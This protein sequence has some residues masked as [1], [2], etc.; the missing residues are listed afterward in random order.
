MT[1]LIFALFTAGASAEEIRYQIDTHAD[2]Q[3]ATA[4]VDIE[5]PDREIRL[6]KY[7]PNVTDFL[8]GYEYVY[9]SP[10]GIERMNVD[11]TTTPITTNISDPNN[12]TA[13]AGSGNRPDFLVAEG[14]F[15]TH[16]SFTGNGYSPNPVLSSAGYTGIVS[17]GTKELD[18]AVLTDHL[19]YMAM[20][21]Q[22][23]MAALPYLTTGD[24]TNPIAASVFKDHYGTVV[25]DGTSVKYF[26][27]GNTVTA[28]ITGLQNAMSI[29]ASEGGNIAV[30]TGNQVQHYNLIGNEFHYNS[31]LSVTTGL[32]E[33][34]CIATRPGSYDKLI[35]DGDQIK[36]YMWTGT[37][38][39]YNPALSKTV[40]GLQAM[41]KYMRTAYAES[42]IYPINKP[43]YV[44]LFIDPGL[45]PQEDGTSIEWY[46]TTQP[47]G[48]PTW[49]PITIGQW[50]PSSNATQIRW[51]AVL[52]TNNPK[53]TPRINPDI[54]IK[55]NTKPLPPTPD[56]PPMAGDD[57][58]YYTTSPEIRW[59]FND[60]PDDFQGGYQI[61]IKGGSLNVSSGPISAATNA[62]TFDDPSTGKI[63]DSGVSVFEVTIKTWDEVGAI[64]G[65]KEEDVASVKKQFCIIA[66]ERPT[67]TLK[68]PAK[69]SATSGEIPKNAGIDN[70]LTTLAGGLI[71][72]EVKSVG[73]S[74]ADFSFPYK[75]E[76]A[77]IEETTSEGSTNKTWTTEFYTDAN[78]D[79][80]PAGTIV[81]G[82][83]N[84]NNISNL[85]ILDESDP[86]E[87]PEKWWQ[88]RGYRKWSDGVVQTGESA[89]KYWNVV[90]QGRDGQD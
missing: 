48:N 53:N 86:G 30:V 82:F 40:A 38:L 69:G 3:D 39:E 14:T 80:C 16:Y 47:D 68:L 78:T 37:A 62:Y 6:P 32:T 43:N 66:F 73:V 85:M 58:C 63:F 67:I 81:H 28:T 24:F 52:K 59:I 2:I 64:M 11:G 23:S 65:F 45:K 7:M 33:P 20:T 29:S 50:I 79:K 56:L 55:A 18:Y 89:Y 26:K 15:V 5:L 70:L 21:D 41:G 13:I 17:I 42:I 76:E 10:T 84:G 87:M 72:M 19:Q 75:N 34:V 90:L 4:V 49:Q 36:Y 1:F 74:S 54:V 25:I 77:T 83:I 60:S 27:E 46:I 44:K 61:D 9:L 12:V 35:V 51:K 31:V 88:W 57:K 8:D 71:T 22:G